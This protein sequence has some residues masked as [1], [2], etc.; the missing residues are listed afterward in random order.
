M[1]AAP[2]KRQLK[3]VRHP[4]GSQLP[5]F[6][7]ELGEFALYHDFKEFEGRGGRPAISDRIE[8]FLHPIF[9]YVAG[10]LSIVI[11]NTREAHDLYSHLFGFLRSYILTHARNK[12]YAPEAEK[13]E[14]SVREFINIKK[15]NRNDAPHWVIEGKKRKLVLWDSELYAELYF[16][17]KD[18]W[19]VDERIEQLKARGASLLGCLS[20]GCGK[21]IIF[22]CEHPDIPFQAISI[23]PMVEELVAEGIEVEVLKGAFRYPPEEYNG[24]VNSEISL[25]CHYNTAA[26]RSLIEAWIEPYRQQSYLHIDEQNNLTG[27]VLKTGA[28]EHFGTWQPIPPCKPEWLDHFQ[29]YSV[30]NGAYYGTKVIAEKKSA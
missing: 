6:A 29:G 13:I 8:A 30:L 27:I 14:K 23:I 16:W 19:S 12:M 18:T 17:N 15:R 9:K 28:S 20:G 22:S 26:Q 21:R 5:P 25:L 3:L 7:Y 2:K 11:D 24:K 4:G 1:S 10:E